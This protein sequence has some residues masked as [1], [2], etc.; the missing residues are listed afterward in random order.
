V[1]ISVGNTFIAD[2][3]L[4]S[5]ILGGWLLFYC[6]QKDVSGIKSAAFWGVL[7][8]IFFLVLVVVNLLYTSWTE[9]MLMDK[10]LN[11]TSPDIWNY[12]LYSCI[13]CIIL[14][15]SF[16][17]YTFSI[18]ECLESP[19][20][21]KMLISSSIGIFI[22][23]LIYLLVGSIGY[24]L[25]GDL[26]LD[27]ILDTMKYSTLT[28]FTSISFVVN[29]VMSFPLTFSALKHYFCFLLQII[30]TMIRDNFNCCLKKNV[31]SA[32][33]SQL[34]DKHDQTANP[35]GPSPNE[36]QQRKLSDGGVS[37]MHPDET[38][39]KLDNVHA[40]NSSESFDEEDEE[41][42]DHHHMHHYVEIP[43]WIENIIVLLIFCGIF[44]V[45]LKY[46]EMK[47]VQYT[48]N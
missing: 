1:S 13:A 26:L 42:E 41:H 9:T 39:I 33:G 2:K 47:K 12:D 20:A 46:Q 17:S 45:A 25:Y 28:I 38:N 3:T 36:T 35:H 34:L 6:Y 31:H 4:L 15:F 23:T 37:A 21:K 44:Y 8:I 43:E 30:L 29:V 18:Y 24:I 19:S 32:A 10:Y 11:F 27:S 5:L 22:S 16:H 7:G 40:D 48:F 14:S